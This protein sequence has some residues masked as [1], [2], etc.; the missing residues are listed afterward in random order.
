[1]RVIVRTPSLLAEPSR[2]ASVL[3]PLAIGVPVV[4]LED[5]GDWLRVRTGTNE[6][7]V[8]RSFFDLPT[9]TVASTT[10]TR[11]EPVVLRS[12]TL[13]VEHA[14][15]GRI[16]ESVTSGTPL[17]VI[18]D[19]GDWVRVKTSTSEGWMPRMYLDFH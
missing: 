6:G 17:T 13:Y 15:N 11:T 12:P 14:F 3:A 5:R 19:R 10:T 4:L 8:Q 18:E 2:E 16:V 1:S 9:Y 7:W